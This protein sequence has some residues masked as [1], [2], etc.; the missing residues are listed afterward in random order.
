MWQFAAGRARTRI[1]VPVAAIRRCAGMYC[2]LR[3]VAGTL[4]VDERTGQASVSTV[5]EACHARVYCWQLSRP[6][7]LAE[8]GHD[9]PS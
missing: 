9:I 5:C 6:Q 1:V 4:R 2:T 8:F 3:P 7:Y